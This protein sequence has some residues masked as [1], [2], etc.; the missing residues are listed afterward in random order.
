MYSNYF[1]KFINNSKNQQMF[2]RLLC[3]SYGRNF[4]NINKK[5]NL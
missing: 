4:Y 3:V 2:I 1:Y 5:I